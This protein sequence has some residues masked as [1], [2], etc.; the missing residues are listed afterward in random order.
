M[1]EPRTLKILMGLLLGY[2]L[3]VIPCFL[4]PPYAESPAGLL[5]VVPGLSIYVFDQA[6]VPGLLEHEG[7]CGWG[8]CAPSVR[9]WV[10]LVV[11]WLALAWLAACGI[12][13]LGN[14]FA[15]R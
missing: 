13:S 12:A 8:W 15:A 11:F 5:L 14:R 6:G 3:L 7:M 4:W 9:G 2:G 10:F 1:L